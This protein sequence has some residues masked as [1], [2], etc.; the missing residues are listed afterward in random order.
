MLEQKSLMLGPSTVYLTD[1]ALKI[2]QHDC[3]T[4]F[5][6][7]APHWTVNAFNTRTEAICPTPLKAFQG[8]NKITALVQAGYNYTAV[9]LERGNQHQ[10]KFGYRTNLATSP[11]S[12]VQNSV[13][14]FGPKSTLPQDGA[15]KCASLESSPLGLKAPL[16]QALILGRYYILGD[17][18]EIP[19]TY[20]C[21]DQIGIRNK[22]LE[23]VSLKK[24]LFSA[25]DFKVP[26]GFKKVGTVEAVRIDKS[27]KESMDNILL[28]LDERLDRQ[29]KK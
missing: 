15:V 19:L 23:T 3:G 13:R 28:N 8:Y 29:H 7:T 5:L 18:Q 9:P 14:Q 20:I 27:G 26:V 24:K 11:K 6:A 1:R 21:E 22:A 16:A 17:L 2:V 10:Y 4:V 25:Q 12:W